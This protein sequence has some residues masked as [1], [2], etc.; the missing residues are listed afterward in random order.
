MESFFYFFCSYYDQYSFELFFCG[1]F[2]FIFVI[3]GFLFLNFDMNLIIVYMLIELVFL[4]FSLMFIS[5][6]LFFFTIDGF[7]LVIVLL[8]LAAIDAVIGLALIL[9]FHKLAYSITLDDFR[10]LIG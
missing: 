9:V 4:A 8:S 6:S 10:F 1:F 5:L 7:L 3:C 2:L